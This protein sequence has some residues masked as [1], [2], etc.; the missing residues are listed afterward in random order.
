MNAQPTSLNSSE[1]LA[2]YSPSDW[3]LLNHANSGQIL[4]LLSIH[5]QLS[6]QESQLYCDLL[7]VYH[8]IYRPA[9]FQM[10]AEGY[11]NPCPPPSITQ[12]QQIAD[13]LSAPPLTVERVNDLLETLA[14]KLREFWLHT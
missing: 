2:P 7:S 4:L 6:V 11:R 8:R 3:T 9:L 12:L 13:S 1:N 10:R 5:L 14:R